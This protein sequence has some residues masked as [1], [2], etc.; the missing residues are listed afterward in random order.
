MRICSR[1][2]A[3]GSRCQN[4]APY[5]DGWCR[6]PECEGFLR[7]DAASAPE[8]PGA[9]PATPWLNDAEATLGD[10]TV[11]DVATVHVAHKAVERF[12]LRHGGESREAEAQ[13][14]SML[15]DFLLKSSRRESA[16]GFLKLAREGYSLVLSPDRGSIV[17]YSTVHRERTWAQ[18]KSGVGSRLTRQWSRPNTEHPPPGPPVELKDFAAGLEPSQIVLTAR[19]RRS[20][21]KLM[22]LKDST[23]DDLDQAIRTELLGFGAAGVSQRA[24]GLFEVTDASKVWLVTQDLRILIGVKAFVA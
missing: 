5:V 13:L 2:R 14:R 15:E 22:D 17:S 18:V 19:V 12:Q 11:E 16:D 7:P 24:D 21:A 6:E 23:D 20:Y 1:F 8:L 10:I 3:D 9:N 4:P